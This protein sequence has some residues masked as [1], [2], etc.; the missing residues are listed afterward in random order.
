MR[1]VETFSGRAFGLLQPAVETVAARKQRVVGDGRAVLRLE[2]VGEEARHFHDVLIGI[3][4]D[5]PAGVGHASS[6]FR[7]R[8]LSMSADVSKAVQ[9]LL[10]ARRSG[11]Q[12]KP[13][14]ALPDRAA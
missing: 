13:T 10:E 8:E 4:N 1:L 7:C 3:V 12:V 11:V 14:V 2:M 9:Q 6:V 5:A